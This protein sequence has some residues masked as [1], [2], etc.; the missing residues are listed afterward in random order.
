MGIG[1]GGNGNGNDSMGVGREWEQESHS[2]TH[3][4]RGRKWILLMLIFM[5]LLFRI[6]FAVSISKSRS[7]IP[8]FLCLHADKRLG[9]AIVFAAQE[10]QEH[11]QNR[12]DWSL[13]LLCIEADMLRSLDFDDEVKDFALAKSR[14]KTFLKLCTAL[15]LHNVCKIRTGLVSV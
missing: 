4:I 9:W 7:C 10:N 8:N 13:S 14:K 3:L 2:R 12:R 1:I 11:V 6:R 15:Q 5:K